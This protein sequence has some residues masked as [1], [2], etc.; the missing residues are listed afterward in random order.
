M[1]GKPSLKES[2]RSNQSIKKGKNKEEIYFYR[3]KGSR[4]IAASGKEGNRRSRSGKE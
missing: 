2:K 1:R 4:S 3:K